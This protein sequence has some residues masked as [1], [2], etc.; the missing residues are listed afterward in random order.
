M[1]PQ[2][3]SSGA[4][5]RDYIVEYRAGQFQNG[6][7]V[8][9]FGSDPSEKQL[10]DALVA[11]GLPARALE[12]VR[13]RPMYPAAPRRTPP[14]AQRFS[15]PASPA[16]SA[17]AGNTPTRGKKGSGRGGGMLL[18][19]V[20]VAFGVIASMAEG[21]I[22]AGEAAG[23][24]RTSETMV[25]GCWEDLGDARDLADP[26]AG[27]IGG[28]FAQAP[29]SFVVSPANTAFYFTCLGSASGG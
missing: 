4:V 14:A 11:H 24:G 22:T 18:V 28:L 10:R 21:A 17:P 7:L 15:A 26:E 8:L 13:A 5:G 25:I 20:L 9:R 19:L 12:E 29:T 27:L 16:P 3:D 2:P 1:S 6:S 23:A